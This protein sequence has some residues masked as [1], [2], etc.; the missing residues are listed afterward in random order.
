MWKEAGVNGLHN[1]FLFLWMAFVTIIL[2]S[3]VIFSCAVGAEKD[4]A[5]TAA[6]GSSCGAE[7]GAGC[8][9]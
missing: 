9:A 4:R 1:D 5:T 8:G 6:G 2:I 3:T 7:C